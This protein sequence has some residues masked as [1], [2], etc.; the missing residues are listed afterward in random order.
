MK[1]ND[2]IE[3]I[4]DVLRNADSIALFT[5]SRPDGDA[6]GS[7]LALKFAL[8]KLGKRVSAFCDTEVGYK[9]SS[10]GLDKFFSLRPSDKY[11]LYVALDCGDSGRLGDL[12]EYFLKQKNTLCIDHHYSHISFCRYNYVVDCSSTC[13]LIFLLLNASEI[14]IDKQIAELLYIGL[15][16]DTGNFSHSNTT[17]A[18]FRVA[19][20]LAKKDIDIADLYDKLYASCRFERT[21]LLGRVLSRIRRYYDGKL[22]LIYVT[23]ED[24][25]ATETAKDDT[26]GFIDYA[27]NVEG[28]RIGVSLCEH[29]PNVYKVSMR[30]KGENVS[31]VC[32]HFG[33]GGHVQ[34]AG[35]MISGFFEDVVDKVLKA[36]RDILWTDL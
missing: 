28:A 17:P 15:S 30:S 8:E 6:L 36:V 26:E 31:E 14:E 11:D 24:F 19:E 16:T 1:K 34:A 7:T 25:D 35:C 21:R 29:G 10:L 20:A 4:A 18:V 13:E 2:A 3:K 33:G 27:V 5:H 23:K 22:C 12:S 9:Y 32:A